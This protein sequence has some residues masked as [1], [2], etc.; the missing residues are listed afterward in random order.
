MLM[1][2]FHIQHGPAIVFGKL[3]NFVHFM[4]SPEPVVEVD[5]RHTGF[6]RGG[7]GDQGHVLRLLHRGGTEHGPAR[8]SASHHVA[9]VAEDRQG[10]GGHGPGRYMEDRRRQFAGNLEHVGDHQQQALGGGKCGG[11]RSGL[12]GA[13]DRTG[14]PGLA[15][16][17]HNQ[18]YRTENVLSSCRC[19]GIGHFAQSGRGRNRINGGHFV[20]QVRYIGRRFIAIDCYEA[21]LCHGL[22][23]L[24]TKKE[25]SLLRGIWNP[26]SA[27][28][29]QI[30]QEGL[31]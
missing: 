10:M 31:A 22:A 7:L 15:L 30:Q 4:R 14:R 12:Q 19:P 25:K 3:F 11:N 5:E 29:A 9:M 28:S 27:H 6:Q 26:L 16:H 17:F 23:P 8:G 13:V 2:A 18:R 21:S 24:K 1:D 20:G